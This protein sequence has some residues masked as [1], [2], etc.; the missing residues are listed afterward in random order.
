MAKE[1]EDKGFTFIDRRRI[2]REGAEE[3]PQPEKEAPQPKEEAPPEIDF[4][5]FTLSLSSQA[6]IQ[7]GDIAD[8][9]SGKK[10][11]N[12]H[13]AKQTIDLLALLKEKTKGN[14]TGEEQELLDRILYDLR[15]R[16]VRESSK[17]T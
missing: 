7:F 13:L 17:P 12:L 1:Q 9:M 5:S 4:V 16:Y 8:P 15:M 14:L 3:A 10:E 6:I 11:K 2:F